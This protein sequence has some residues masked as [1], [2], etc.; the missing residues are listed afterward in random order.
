M[1][2]FTKEINLPY[3]MIDCESRLRPTAF[4]DIA[5]EMAAAGAEPLGFADHHLAPLNLVWIL[6]RMHVRFDRMPV[7]RDTVTAETWHTG[8]EGLFSGREY[9]LLDKDGGELIRGTSSWI[10]MDI[11][12]RRAVRTDRLDGIIDLSAQNSEKLFE[13]GCAK[14]VPPRGEVFSPAGEHTV[15]YSDLD[16]N[17]HVNNVKYSVWAFDVLPLELLRARQVRELSINFNKEALPGETVSLLSLQVGDDWYIE[18]RCEDRQ[19]FIEKISF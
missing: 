4:L 17:G 3:Y 5:Q 13:E 18:G 14:I 12:T 6:A 7:R 1:N 16:C 11:S 8:F 15:M 2:K 9:R 19:I 10:L